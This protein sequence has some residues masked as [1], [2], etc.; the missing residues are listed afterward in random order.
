MKHYLVRVTR[1]D[2]L[3]DLRYGDI[4]TKLTVDYVA[5]ELKL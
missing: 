4:C 3:Y 5:Y 1:I 2:P